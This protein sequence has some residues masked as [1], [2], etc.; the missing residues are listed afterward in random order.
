M[1][2]ASLA[3]SQMN[4]ESLINHIDVSYQAWHGGTLVTTSVLDVDSD[5]YAMS[6]YLKTLK[7]FS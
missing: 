6:L 5:G 2:M 3:D 1:P 7:S 4:E